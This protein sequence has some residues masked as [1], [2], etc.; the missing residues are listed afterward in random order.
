M[1][2]PPGGGAIGLYYA[3]VEALLRLRGVPRRRRAFSDLQLIEAA[4]LAELNREV[5]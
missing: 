4:A 2:H 5:L 1:T 3:G